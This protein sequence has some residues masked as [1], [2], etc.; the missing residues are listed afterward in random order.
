MKRTALILALLVSL[1]LPSIAHAGYPLCEPVR[2]EPECAFNI[3]REHEAA[4]AAAAEAQKAAAEAAAAAAK[5]AQ[6]QAELQAP[7]TIL[8]VTVRSHHWGSYGEPGE[9]D[10]TATSSPNALIDITASAA[11]TLEFGRASLAVLWSCHRRGQIVRYTVEAQGGEGTPP[12][13]RT[14][15]FK[16]ALSSRWCAAARR[17]EAS[18]N[19]RIR[20]EEHKETAERAQHEREQRQ[21]EIEHFETNC[22]ALGGIPVEIQIGGHPWVVCHNKTGGIINVPL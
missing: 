22:R 4:E 17:R 20:A 19:A 3:Q 21:H 7:A 14:G 6:E 15:T 16:I 12:L 1:A 8:D 11:Y 10:I 5:A 18:E 9:T 13:V 2:I